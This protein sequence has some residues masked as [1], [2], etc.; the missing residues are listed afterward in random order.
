MLHSCT[1]ILIQLLTIVWMLK[2]EFV[3]W[4]NSF[5]QL[6]NVHNKHSITKVGQMLHMFSYQ[7]YL[8]CDCKFIEE[9]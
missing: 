4:K 6:Q 1:H 5:S 9:V 8:L 7:C 3:M 2:I